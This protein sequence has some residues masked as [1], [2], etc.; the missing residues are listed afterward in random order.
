MTREGRV[1]ANGWTHPSSMTIFAHSFIRNC[2]IQKVTICHSNVVFSVIL[3]NGRNANGYSHQRY[4][5]TLHLHS[6]G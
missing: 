3:I 6:W 2:D 5:L 4:Q 1:L